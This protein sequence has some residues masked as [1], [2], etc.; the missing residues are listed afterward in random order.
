MPL[1]PV[2]LGLPFDRVA[3]VDCSFSWGSDDILS[4][5]VVSDTVPDYMAKSIAP[6]KR[7][8]SLTMVPWCLSQIL[9]LMIIGFIAWHLTQSL[10]LN[11][12]PGGSMVL[13]MVRKVHLLISQLVIFKTST[14]Y[15]SRRRFASRVVALPLRSVSLRLFPS[16]WNG[17]EGQFTLLVSSLPPLWSV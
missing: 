16:L 1:D 13:T 12:I 11:A 9:L 5:L 6:V 14:I 15:L 17:F 4:Y 3:K 10:K 8:E 7:Q 2:L